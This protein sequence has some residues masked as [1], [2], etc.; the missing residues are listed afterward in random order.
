MEF[1]Q[2]QFQQYL[3]QF[4]AKFKDKFK[5]H[6]SEQPQWDIFWQVFPTLASTNQKL[7][8][9]IDSGINLPE[10]VNLPQVVIAQQQTAGKGQWGRIWQSQ[11]GGLYLSLGLPVNI[12]TTN[13]FDLILI[14]AWGITT[15]LRQYHLPVFIKWPNDLILQGKKLGG[16]LTETRILQ[17]KIIYAV[18]GVGINWDNS[19]PN[20]GIKLQDF[21]LSDSRYYRN[22][23]AS[24]E[25]LAA[26]TIEGI[27]SAYQKYLESGK[28]S[29]LKCYENLL[30]IR[31]NE[32]IW[33]GCP[34][35][36]LGLT[37]QGELRVRLSSQG[38]TTEIHL[39]PGALSLGYD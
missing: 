13:A 27:L 9:L 30:N 28:S 19:V 12:P 33:Q 1:H 25:H 2:H 11:S 6:F 10:V 7:W 5:D 35:I 17:D 36:I 34:G 29:I 21:Y 32:I 23:I 15:I 14:S 39:P 16:I 24:L 31:G 26:L 8:D 20:M 38:S 37:P 18:I 3:D 4:K 22:Q